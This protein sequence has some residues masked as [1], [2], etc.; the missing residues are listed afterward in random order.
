MFVLFAGNDVCTIFRY[1][2]SHL[3]QQILRVGPETVFAVVFDGGTDFTATEPM[4][5]Q[6]WPW[7]SFTHCSSHEVSLIM[8]DCFKEDGDIRELSDLNEWITDAQHWFSTH[9]MKGL[10]QQLAQP[11]ESKT[12]IWPA[13]TRYCGT[14][15]KIKRFREMRELLRRVVSSGVYVEKNFKEDPIKSKVLAAEMWSLM[16]KVIKIMGPLLLLCRLADGQKPVMSKLYGTQLYVREKIES[17][18]EESAIGSVERKISAVFLTRWKEMQSDIVSAT[19][20]LEPLFVDNSKNAAGCIIKL[21]QLA[22][23]VTD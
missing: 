15:L 21:W 20:C 2:A 5:Q 23:K 14:L 10:I 9:A 19:Y 11:G 12:F 4:I 22:R 7:I 17:V 8:K 16:D 6:M 1:V 18:A 13:C 3:K